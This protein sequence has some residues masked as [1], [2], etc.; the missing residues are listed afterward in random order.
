MVVVHINLA[1]DNAAIRRDDEAQVVD[2][3][4]ETERGNQTDV[5]AF[6]RLDWAK[7]TIVGIVNVTDL[8]TCTLTGE[9]ARTQCGETAL[10]RHLGKGVGLVHKLAQRV[11]T[12]ERVDDRRDGLGVDEVRRLEHLVVAHVHT[13]TDGTG[14]TSQTDR[15]LVGKLLSHRTDT[16][17]G[18]V[19]DII[20]GRIGVDQLDEILDDLNDILLRQDADIRIGGQAKLLVDTIA[21]YLAQV[22]TLVREEKV[23]EY[24]TR[25]GIVGSIGIA[26]L[27]IDVVDGLDLRVARVLL[28]GVEDDGI[29]IG[30]L[31]VLM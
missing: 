14:H 23:L 2:L 4:I 1:I 5:R 26:K 24:L 28:Q 8:E 19:V 16:A 9:T 10:V 15:E 20:H 17:V 25:T 30:H 22:I 11:R 18:K 31:L 29:L 6:R 7:A 3:G 27:T 12:E 21:A 13:L